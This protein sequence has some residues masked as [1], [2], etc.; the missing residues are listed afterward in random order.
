MP[1]RV[2]KSKPR[3]LKR[4]LYFFI[5]CRGNSHVLD[6]DAS[7]PLTAAPQFEAL[8]LVVDEQNPA[9]PR[10]ASHPQN[11]P[12]YDDL[13]ASMALSVS[14]NPCNK[15]CEN[16]YDPSS[17]SQEPSDEPHPFEADLLHPSRLRD[18]DSESRTLGSKV[19]VESAKGAFA[20]TFNEKTFPLINARWEIA[21]PQASNRRT[22]LLPQCQGFSCGAGHRQ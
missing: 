19:S 9:R 17:N 6:D 22:L 12:Q 3:L 18:P 21:G 15:S 2:N 16:F 20:V 13:T 4:I 10:A 14:S 5:P 11:T 7:V 1:L 8:R